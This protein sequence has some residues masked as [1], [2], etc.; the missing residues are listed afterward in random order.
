M[1]YIKIIPAAWFAVAV[2]NSVLPITS[3]NMFLIPYGIDKKS[4]AHVITWSTIICVPLT[5]ILISLFS[6]YFN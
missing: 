5:V 6:F 1:L 4:T 2:I 3:T